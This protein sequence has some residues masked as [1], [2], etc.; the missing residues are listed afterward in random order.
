MN[1]ESSELAGT[2][3]SSRPILTVAELN[4]AVARMIERNFPLVW[5]AGEV[6]NLTRAASG[7]WY[8]SLKDREAQVRCV[9]FRNRN[10]LL[11]W[12]PREGD[13]V[14]ARALAGLYAPRGDFQL[15][16]EQ[17]RRAGAGSLYEAF[18]RLKEKLQAEGLFA[19]ERKRVLPSFPR[20][21]G[22][23]TSLQ[24]AA[25]R[26]VLTTLAR[27]APQVRVVLYPTPVQGADAP[28]QIVRSIHMASERAARL[29]ECEVLLVVRGGGSIEDLWAFNDER[30]ARAMA[31]CT[32]PVIS[33]V[34]HETDFTI[35]DFVADVRAA[36]PTA[37]AE[38]A[39]PDRAQLLL[40]LDADAQAMRRALERSLATAEQKLDEANRRLKSPA[41]RWRDANDQLVRSRQRLVRAQSGARLQAQGRL[42]LAR[43]ALQ[44]GHPDLHHHE[45]ALMHSQERGKRALISTCVGQQSRLA[46]LAARLGLLNPASALE[47]GYA[48]AT[49]SQ[50]RIVRDAR[51]LAIGSS[52]HL[53]LAQGAVQTEVKTIET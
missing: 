51:E 12:Q 38:L 24:A 43:I 8:F 33:G 18:L 23:V 49:D 28:E 34:G 19:I 53:R 10:Q 44:R 4:A 46:V 30:V 1:I 39:S 25:L 6:S 35:A 40:A 21:I 13:R 47:R 41:Q 17:L 16:I 11:D 3:A 20:T 22:L 37:A 32:V 27:R 9:M 29:G 26:D 5:V 50:G 14:E 52:L 2:T 15:N 36:T 45:Q 42:N 7:H 48:I 31:Q